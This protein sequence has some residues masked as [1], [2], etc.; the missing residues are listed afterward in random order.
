M[1]WLGPRQ[2]HI[3][4]HGAGGTDAGEV[5]DHALSRGGFGTRGPLGAQGQEKEPGRFR[6][7]GGGCGARATRAQRGAFASPAGETPLRARGANPADVFNFLSSRT[8]FG[9]FSEW[10]TP[11]LAAKHVQ[12]E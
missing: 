4:A 9:V 6:G 11:L 3:N 1:Q 5:P 7:A 2:P 10:G 8:F 12:P